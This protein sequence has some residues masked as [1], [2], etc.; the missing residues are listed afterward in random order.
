MTNVE[1]IAKVVEGVLISYNSRELNG[2]KYGDQLAQVR[3]GEYTLICYH[4]GKD[5]NNYATAVLYK[6]DLAG[7]YPPE[8]I[9]RFFPTGVQS[10]IEFVMPFYSR[11]IRGNTKGIVIRMLQVAGIENAINNDL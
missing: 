4:S 9:F 11:V 7:E 8:E 2:C 5:D 10:E 3:F 6:E 1:K